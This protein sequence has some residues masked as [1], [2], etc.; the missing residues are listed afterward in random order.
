M[1]I[2]TLECIKCISATPHLYIRRKRHYYCSKCSPFIINKNEI[3]KSKM[4][5]QI[6]KA[7]NRKIIDI[8][9][10]NDFIHDLI[11]DFSLSELA[12]FSSLSTSLW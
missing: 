12:I 4:E 5:K 6:S 1:K 11:S 9:N 7:L 8:I 3:F 10:D 2:L